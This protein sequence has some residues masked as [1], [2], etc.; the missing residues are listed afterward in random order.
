MKKYL[1]NIL[2]QLIFFSTGSAVFAQYTITGR[3]VSEVSNQ[4]I[5]KVSISTKEGSQVVLTD[6]EG[7]F[8]IS[9]ANSTSLTARHIGYIDYTIDLKPENTSLSLLIRL[10]PYIEQLKEVTVISTGYQKVP[11]ERATGSFAQI[12]NKL[13]NRRVS[14]DILS[15]LVDA[16]PGLIFNHESGASANSISIRGQNTINANDQPLI[17]LNNFPYD[18][19]I[20][21]INPN[22]VESVTI[23]KDAAAAS[24]WGARAGNGVIVITTKK[25]LLN[26]PLQISINS[27]LTVGAKPDLYYIP[28]MAS[29]DYIETEKKLFAQDYYSTIETSISKQPLSPVVELLIAKRE[30]KISAADADRKIEQLKSL[31]VNNDYNTYLQRQSVNQQYSINLKGGGQYHRYFVSSG[32]DKNLSNLRGNDFN[33]MTLNIG[34]SF[35]LLKNKLELVTNILYTN[36]SS[37]Q[38]S[39]GISN[40][41]LQGRNLYPYAQ[42][43]G[44]R[45]NPLPVARNYRTS[46]INEL[47]NDAIGV[48]D[49]NYIPLQELRLSNNF[50]NSFDYLINTEAKYSIFK[51][52]DASVQYQ[53]GKTVSKTENLN[54]ADSYYV[55]NLINEF[56]IINAGMPT[57]RPVPLGGIL[58]NSNQSSVR[59]NLRTQLT[60]DKGF[61]EK[62]R[63]NAIAGAEIRDLN[64]IGNSYRFYGYDSEHATSKAVDYVNTYSNF[65]DPQSNNNLIPNLDSRQELSDRYLSYYSNIAYTFDDR[66]IV[67]V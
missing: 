34:N 52:L 58:D 39:P 35:S 55:R 49:W 60:F 16:V 13:L 23:L 11:K 1:N 63:L 54:N 46:Y 65:V 38:N 32:Y 36:S 12:D 26:Q 18:G 27:N 5:E 3:V 66:I 14:T 56:T 4:P 62:H 29:A 67:S 42:L 22:D 8:T 51:E 6:N 47:A 24:I 57:E 28:V 48:L 25:G 7:K 19:D 50:A 17:V 30:G 41:G 31:D 15:R 44:E 43:A 59:N 21:N 61:G 40:L 53:Y 64:I 2:L 45:G 20:S 37:N 10:R 9:I 33:R